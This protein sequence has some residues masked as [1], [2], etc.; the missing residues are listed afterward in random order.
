M[1]TTMP[2]TPLPHSVTIQT[3]TVTLDG[4]GQPTEAWADEGRVR[5]EIKQVSIHNVAFGRETVQAKQVNVDTAYQFVIRYR[6]DF[7][8]LKRFKFGSRVF[9]ILN[10]NNIEER[11]RWLIILCKEVI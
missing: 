4:A 7:T 9:N 11:N 1:T 8:S 10:V 3:P 6:P 2:C 5:A